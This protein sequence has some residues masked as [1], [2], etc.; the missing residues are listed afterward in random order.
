MVQVTNDCVLNTNFFQILNDVCQSCNEFSCRCVNIFNNN[1]SVNVHSL[2]AKHCNAHVC[3][4]NVRKQSKSCSLKNNNAH[5]SGN[6]NVT[7]P[8]D[9]ENEV[10]CDND[11]NNSESITEQI[12]NINMSNE[13]RNNTLLTENT[14]NEHS[15]LGLVKRGLRIANLNIRHILPKIDEIKYMLNGKRSVDVLGI[16]ETFLKDDIDDNQLMIDG[17]SIERRDRKE[18][19]G[20]GV[21]VYISN[22][23]PFERRR[24]LE[25]SGIE[26]L[27]IQINLPHSKPIL[28]RSLY[29]PPNSLSEWFNRFEHE[30][31]T[32][33]LE[34]D[35]EIILA[36][37][38]NID[39]LKSQN[40]E[41]QTL[42]ELYSFEQL[43]NKAT[44]VSDKSQTLIDHVYTNKPE[45]ISEICVPVYAASDHYPVCITRHTPS[46][47]KK[48]THTEITYRYTKKF[49]DNDFMNDLRST[50]L[51]DIEKLNDC[52]AALEQ[53]YLL[54]NQVVNKH[55][56]IR[57]K[58][59]KRQHKTDWLSP[60][61]IESMH[62]RDKFHKCK[63][64]DNY[65][66][67][68]NIV[69]EQISK[70]KEDY[71]KRAIRENQNTCNIWK[72]L[73]D[74]NGKKNTEPPPPI[75]TK[76]PHRP[77]ISPM[78]SVII[79]RVYIVNIKATLLIS[80][81]NN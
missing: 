66:K 13:C 40:S 76:P 38:F 46:M 75:M 14:Y 24:D 35:I 62:K 33:S 22:N 77:K 48:H 34:D 29:R 79:F 72:Y 71:Y 23:L 41:W 25:T 21:L 58:R 50:P 17:F 65:R 7:T 52:N 1:L 2:E 11:K 53:L 18:K 28:F 61:I 80:I 78:H 57:K 64:W 74:L 60:E 49:N 12:P 47:P 19:G 36:G 37:D 39:L 59:V 9:D 63:D 55:A 10:S 15:T 69:S 67:W 51:N 6:S 4:N 16:C 73:N 27:W 81:Q 3:L 45:N 44:R 26:S 43:I 42:Y 54:L 8:H 5:D 32:A 56:P 68:R 70:S 30:I 20:G 31:S